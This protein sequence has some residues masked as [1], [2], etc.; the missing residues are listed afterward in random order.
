M[1]KRFAVAGFLCLLLLV[2]VCG[3]GVL[4]R[5]SANGRTYDDTAVI[6]HRESGLVLGCSRVLSD[7]RL[8][9]FF[10]YRINAAAQLFKAR[11][12]DTIIVSGDNHAAGYDEPTDMKNALIEAGVPAEQIHCDYAGFRTLDSVVRAKAIF[13]QTNITVI[14]QKFHNQRAIYIAR[15]RGIDAIG[16]N[17]QEVDVY[18][19]TRTK[20][21]EQ[22]AR[23]KTVLD[24]WFGVRPKFSGPPVG[25]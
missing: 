24:M 15:S 14:S 12:I 4:I 9:L 16:F 7:G 10:A 8:N 19:G 11:K 3:A 5:A 6:P 23:V 21:R 20:L 2:A 17:A 25:I 1:K 18:N 13:G 22:F